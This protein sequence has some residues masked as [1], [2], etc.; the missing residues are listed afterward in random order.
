MLTLDDLRDAV[1]A[2]TGALRFAVRVASLPGLTSMDW[3]LALLYDSATVDATVTGWNLSDPV[4]VTGLGWS[5]LADRIEA[6]F[7]DQLG[8]DQALASPSYTLVLAGQRYQLVPAGGQP[9]SGAYATVPREFWRISY[10]QASET[11]TVVLDDGSTL[12]FGGSGTGRATV[13]WGYAWGNWSGATVQAAG[14]RPL[15]VGWSLAQRT[16]VWGNATRF[17]YGQTEAQLGGNPP[18]SYTR[19]TRLSRIDGPDG[20]ALV[21]H[22]ADKEPAEYTDPFGGASGPAWQ[23][24]FGAMALASVD[25]VTPGGA[26]VATTTLSYLGPG[27]TLAAVGTGDRTK[28]L[29]MG[30]TRQA[31]GGYQMPALS[32]GYDT[33][34]TSASYG[35]LTSVITEAG[36]EAAISYA[37]PQLTLPRRDIVLAPPAAGYAEPRIF[38]GSDYAVVLWRA[39]GGSVHATGYRWQG[40][41]L[42]SP[43]AAPA[44]ADDAAYQALRVACGQD[45]FA[46]V[47]T[48]EFTVFHAD[49]AEPGGWV[50]SASAEP[51]GLPSGE[52]VALAAG[53]GYVALAAGSSGTMTVRW[54]DGAAWQSLACPA[55]AGTVVAA[56][57]GS[58][59]TLV[60]V[61]SAG[62][63]DH[64]VLIAY[65]ERSGGS[66]T[67]SAFTLR[68]WVP[69]LDTLR[70]TAGVSHAVI[71][72]AGWAGA[73]Q[74]VSYTAA[75]WSVDLTGLS[76]ASLSREVG[77]PP[78]GGIAGPQVAGASVLIGQDA[79]RFDGAAWRHQD[80]SALT[81]PNQ[82]Q[83]VS[84]SLGPD[85]VARSVRLTDGSLLY[86]LIT[87]DPASTSATPWGYAAG[88][89][90]LP[91]RAGSTTAMAALPGPAGQGIASRFVLLN[92]SLYLR[93]GDGSW[94][95]ALDVQNV[96]DASNI[97]SLVLAGSS[98]L[99][100][101]T[102]A[103]VSAYPL[104]CGGLG[105]PG[106]INLPGARLL[107]ASG[108]ALAGPGAFVGYTGTW[109][110][111]AAVLTLYRA[112]A[113]DVRGPVT[114][115]AVTAVVLY[116]SGGMG[117]TGPL[118][119]DAIPIAYDHGTASATA[120][121]DGR[122]LA[123]SHATA[124]EAGTAAQ[125]QPFGSVHTYLFSRL[126]AAEPPELP[127]PAGPQT[128]A[129]A[130]LGYLAGTAY[131]VRTL[132]HTGA[133][134][135]SETIWW[136]VQRTTPAGAYCRARKEATAADG[137]PSERTLS[138]H[139]DTGMLTELDAMLA[140]GTSFRT[141]YTY[142]WQAYDPG[143]TRN[144]LTPV[145]GC[146]QYAGSALL[147]GSVTTWTDQWAAGP[148]KWAPRGSYLAAGPAPADFTDWTDDPLAPPQGWQLTGLITDRTAVG[149]VAQTRDA[150]GRVSSSICSADGS[151][152]LASFG[153]AD[154]AG[155]EA[156]HYNC[157]PYEDPGP[158]AYRGGTIDS[159]LVAGESNL[160][161]R[162]LQ[163]TADP[164]GATGPVAAWTP[165]G[166][167]RSY[168]F[169]CWVQTG[170]GLVAGDAAFVLSARAGGADIGGTTL[171]FPATAGLWA[172]VSVIVPLGAW[173][174]AHGV[175]AGTPATITVLGTNTNAGLAVF[176]DALRFQPCDADFYASVPDPATGLP[177]GSLQL[178]GV[179]Y[180]I[181]RDANQI[182]NATVGP[183]PAT[184]RLGIPAFARLAT[185]DGTFA[186]AFPN[187]LLEAEAGTTA[188]Y[189][190]F[191]AS[192]AG[193]WT[194]PAG[195]TVGGGSLAFSGSQPG[196][197]GSMAMLTGFASPS[198]VAHVR[199]TPPATGAAPDVGIGCGNVLAVH[200]AGPDAWMLASTT[201]GQNWTLGTQ[202]PGPLGRGDL[203]FALLDG[204]VT[205]FAAG[206]QVFSQTVPV[207]LTPDGGL[208][209]CLTGPG[210]F[211]DLVALTDPR[212]RLVL[213]DGRGLAQQTVDLRSASQVEALG[214]VTDPLGQPSYGKNAV[215]VPLALDSGRIAGAPTSYLP[216]AG[217]N[218]SPTLDEY[219]AYGN[220]SPFVRGVPE[221]APLARLS[222]LG[223][224]G[225]DLA[226][227]SG[228]STGVGYSQ[229][230][231][232]GVMAG[233]VPDAQAGNYELVAVTDP[234][235]NVNYRLVSS[236]GE[237]VARRVMLGAGA[238]LTDGYA[239]DPAGR[240]TG[241]T[242]PNGYAEAN[243]AAW[244]T[245]YTRDFIGQVI[246][247]DSPDEQ[248]SQTGYDSAG[249]PRF[250]QS[251]AD[252]AASPALIGYRKYDG[253]DR[254]VEQGSISG[255]AWPA[256]LA[257][258]D[259]QD[260]PDASVTHAVTR[261]MS[262]DAP[263]IDGA[264]CT[265]GRLTGLTVYA[266]DGTVAVNESYG[267]DMAG[268]VI[269]QQ[270]QAPGYSQDT[271]VTSYGYDSRGNVTLVNFPRAQTDGSPPLSVAY[272]YDSE[273]RITAVGQ[274][275]P[276]GFTDPLNPPPD[277][278]GRYGTFSY[279]PDGSLAAASYQNDDPQNQP[280]TVSYTYSPAG[281]PLST[282][283]AVY[284]EQLTYTSGGYGGAGSYL[285]QPASA[286][287]RWQASPDALYPLLD[288]TAQYGY[289]Q[290]G[291]LTA[292]APYLAPN[293]APPGPGEPGDP[294][295]VLDANG[296][297]LT[298]ARGDATA[299]YRY[300]Q[301]L[302][303]A[304]ATTADPV[305][306]SD[307][308]QT[309]AV[310]LAS[311]CSFDVPPP[312]GWSWG[313]SDGGPGGASV[314]D[315][316]PTT[317]K[318][319]NVPGS[320]L[321]MAG[322]LGYRGYADPR[323]TYT[324]QYWLKAD[325]GFAAQP[326]TAGWYMVLLGPAGPIASLLAVA[327]TSPPVTWTQQSV[328]FDLS[329][330]Y[331]V[332]GDW[333]QTVNVAFVL[334]N[335]RGTQNGTLGAALQVDDLVLAGSG[336]LGTIEYDSS[337]RM[338][339]LTGAGFTAMSYGQDSSTLAI[340]H[341]AAAGGYTMS[342]ALGETGGYAA[343]RADPVDPNGVPG[344]TLYLRGPDGRLLERLTRWGGQVSRRLYITGPA[345][346]FAVDDD[347][348]LSYVIGSASSG[349]SAVTDIGGNL[350][351]F[352]DTDAFGAVYASGIGGADVLGRL[353]PF[354][355]FQPS[356]PAPYAP[357][358]GRTVA[359]KPRPC[360]PAKP[361][362]AAAQAG[363]YAAWIEERSWL[364]TP[365]NF[366]WLTF[367]DGTTYM[368]H[369]PDA[370]L[371][372]GL[373]AKGV[374]VLAATRGVRGSLAAAAL[375]S[376]FVG[377][378]AEGTLRFLYWRWQS[379]GCESRGL[380]PIQQPTLIEDIYHGEVY[381]PLES[382]SGARRLRLRSVETIPDGFYIFVVTEWAE[383]RYL[384]MSDRAGGTELYVRHSMLASG[385]C[386][387]TAGM[388]AVFGDEI[389]L[390]NQSGHYQPGRDLV[391][392][393]A[394]PL[395]RAAGYDQ[396]R[397]TVCTLEEIDLKAKMIEFRRRTGRA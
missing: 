14:R 20:A 79:Y 319:L 7:G 289:D 161:T 389:V 101:Q 64:Q 243:Q 29:L 43:L 280:I 58:A 136:W 296:N 66:W 364:R 305:R 26:V 325:P 95:S 154:I 190:N 127:Y 52:P 347:G 244:L 324:L 80:L 86:D 137:V 73:D 259:N 163:I 153:N 369:N 366:L 237:V 206:R 263:A 253:I 196:V 269:T 291:R 32:F 155:Q 232:S 125:P 375:A 185:A 227:G 16:D 109:G 298:V 345:G 267:Y 110:D 367:V 176:V 262:Y 254:V 71:T 246:E 277:L 353:D 165:A 93:A 288:Y 21:L 146:M 221:P 84:L 181:I 59:G 302:A 94:S 88:L 397:I 199:F 337:G 343:R 336:D 164:T 160:G 286:R 334:R 172:Y 82:N 225:D 320:A 28:R 119:Y 276:G 239:S 23:S 140:D 279:G 187:T 228:H 120:S 13:D 235:G 22:Y 349:S 242:A 313:S 395:L 184:A 24:R 144:L 35:A 268:R 103:G 157:E 377:P 147:R 356:Q 91:A 312:P 226:V 130:S 241:V 102:T 143:R 67:T 173:R 247:I 219:L 230:T 90:A 209:L 76:S 321:G 384:D 116:A 340:F 150:L 265:E 346:T 191:E 222:Q 281:W 233:L 270:A 170:A 352:Y 10:T 229:N 372:Y 213:L 45:C 27:G 106:G 122:S 121:D 379:G 214:A 238:S 348:T 251:A 380:R 108:P 33:D 194:L 207:G 6:D 390:T 55:P 180:R 290:A 374:M 145:I 300:P 198:Y 167:A 294:P 385:G 111:P 240:L 2:Y 142:W 97:A 195:W 104:A 53:A 210:S 204:R 156:Y 188:E 327:I 135:L 39:A 192:D 87:Y 275:P 51:I 159:H 48:A 118:P 200:L 371:A 297:L 264:T 174:T 61:A 134:V 278:S 151:R 3:P 292:A 183:D 179:A 218:D 387:Q 301:T 138:Y 149:L 40:R 303:T 85:A 5:L 394:V 49:P 8:S 220:G 197:P 117:G 177:L 250:T 315:G 46:I 186:S 37:R 273:G 299:S 92:N 62:G 266:A 339:A 357:W 126:T 75:W 236:S 83:V 171:T 133:E 391:E 115:L 342:F 323:G 217:G 57:D 189:Q 311:S 12:T 113:E 358:L 341:T 282:T 112:V 158:W 123:V 284:S 386:V 42:P 261:A 132:S 47:G 139:P 248:R 98:Y 368:G 182:A 307:R 328:T 201:D 30:L 256:A 44:A 60:R 388:M 274:P 63:R 309:V 383:F 330:L 285:G 36:G 314:I 234:D 249:R 392:K 34:P 107:P 81:H 9:G 360:P 128:N 141:T 335:H 378:Y 148:G 89:S 252:A 318:C 41:W 322:V 78:A 223:L 304:R 308:L 124:T 396:Y 370:W 208:R 271:W 11:W 260:W 344:A 359:P 1:D 363:G 382:I 56:I 283:S 100:F 168:L 216:P 114:P 175:S 329:G 50:G 272:S 245:S 381:G 74:V 212:L 317:G 365:V 255:V 362:T 331:Q 70:V 231:A 310:T 393:Y 162:C 72:M 17:S 105:A 131:A 202:Y 77:P 326:G 295:V 129:T 18:A 354:A 68:E 169:S 316:G 350:T 166:Q 373:A 287:R 333:A 376:A 178:N 332:H 31:P 205:V 25:E 215:T 203:V 306:P 38:F 351:D 65:P 54:F 293:Q 258:A 224:P 69:A 152:Q 193:Q 355:P 19:D 338:T 4:G 96:F 257:Q 99:A 211:S 361:A 15:A